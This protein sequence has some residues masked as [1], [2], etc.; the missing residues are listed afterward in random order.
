[1]PLK[2]LITGSSGYIGSHFV[3]YFKRNGA[4]VFGID[5]VFP[6]KQLQK[7]FSSH[8]VEDISNVK[9]VSDFL[10][11]TKPEL[12]I[13]C[14]A[15][16]LISE[17][18]EQPAMYHEYNVLKATAFLDLCLSKNIPNF[19]YSSTAATYGEPIK[20]PIKENHPQNP[21]NNYGK[22]KLE[23]ERILLSKKELCVGILRYFNAAGADP[24]TEIGE[25]HEPETHLIP[26]VIRAILDGKPIFVHGNTYP[27]KDGTCVRDYIHVMDLKDM[28]WRL[29]KQMIEKK[30]GGIYNLG[31]THGYSILEVIKTAEKIIG[32]KTQILFQ[33]KR[34]GDPSILIADAGAAKN[35]FDWTPQHSSLENM[36]ETA[37]KWHSK[38]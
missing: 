7:Y 15:K 8:I 31:S 34:P 9:H 24:E 5:L 26:N 27:T 4:D 2:I 38:G 22:T 28:H 25:H 18:N 3:K 29:A 14:A 32:K 1:M 16:C 20:S 23:F 35:D 30:R 6:P 37:L 21:I 10:D 36:I 33:G 11:K 17:S 12:I 19:L 13:H